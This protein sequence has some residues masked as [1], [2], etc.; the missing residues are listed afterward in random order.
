MKESVAKGLSYLWSSLKLNPIKE[1][2]NAVIGFVQ[3][4][5]RLRNLGMFVV[6][7]GGMAGGC[8]LFIEVPA[9]YDWGNA[10]VEGIIPGTIINGFNGLAEGAGAV[11]IDI[12]TGALGLWLGGA[13]A[14]TGAKQV[15]RAMAYS[16]G[17]N[18]N[19]EYIFTASEIDKFNALL[20]VEA[21]E[22]PQ[23]NCGRGAIHAVTS[24]ILPLNCFAHF[25]R[26]LVSDERNQAREATFDMLQHMV[27]D[28]ERYGHDGTFR[29]EGFKHPLREFFAG[30]F[31][32]ALQNYR[33]RKLQADDRV[34]DAQGI[35]DEVNQLLNDEVHNPAQSANLDVN[36]QR[37]LGQKLKHFRT[38]NSTHVRYNLFPKAMIEPLVQT[39]GDL[40]SLKLE[41]QTQLAKQQRV[42]AEAEQVRQRF[43]ILSV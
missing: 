29:R 36:V 25:Q 17:G 34:L 15:Y 28:C 4:K 24:R 22:D 30:R 14:G 5:K 18:T 10:I 19:T 7:V 31:M 11:V 33:K 23:I 8:V 43:G 12:C 2:F 1:A 16:I 3:G 35:I 39:W 21:G 27:A 26:G 9:F 41:A 38:C 42:S 40:E 20:G 6:L 13:T 32:P 37:R